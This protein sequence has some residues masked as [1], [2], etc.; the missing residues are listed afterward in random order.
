MS[1][2]PLT[3]VLRRLWNGRV[4]L[5][6]EFRR[7]LGIDEDALLLLT[8]KAGRIEIT[9]V[10]A[11]SIAEMGA[12]REVYAMLKLV[13]REAKEAEEAEISALLDEVFGEAGPEELD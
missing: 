13:G 9:P 8:L 3:Q 6:A 1:D 7:Q 5:P 2:R 4:A 11:E 12:S 10:S